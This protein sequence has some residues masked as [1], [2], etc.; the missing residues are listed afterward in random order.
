MKP[1]TLKVAFDSMALTAIIVLAN[2]WSPV[3]ATEPNKGENTALYGTL[4]VVVNAL[5]NTP[6]A[7][8]T[9]VID[10]DTTKTATLLQ[11]YLRDSATLNSLA[12]A[13]DQAE[14][15]KNP[16]GKLEELC[17]KNKATKCADAA[18]YLKSRGTTLGGHLI[19]NTETPSTVLP[20]INRTL[21]LLTNAIDQY[22]KPAHNSAGKSSK[23]LLKTAV[24]GK[25]A[26]D[27][28][29]RLTGATTDRETTCGKVEQAG[30]ASGRSIAE[31]LICIC[32]STSS[33]NN[34]GC[35]ASG[36]PTV[37]FN[38]GNNN[39]AAAWKKLK[40]GCGHFNLANSKIS[41]NDIRQTIR[42]VAQLI[43]APHGTNQKIGYLGQTHDSNTAGACDGNNDSGGKGACVNYGKSATAAN[44]PDW[45]D[46]LQQAAVALDSEAGAAQHKASLMETISSLNKTLTNLLHLHNTQVELSKEIKQSRGTETVKSTKTLEE[47]NKECEAI[48]KAGECREKEPA[49]EWKRENDDDGP[50]SKLNTRAAEKIA[51]QA[52]AGAGTMT[53]GC[54][55][56]GTDKEKCE[57]HTNGK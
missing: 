32:G 20:E 33:T 30:T 1:Q 18:K 49:C 29:V 54:A 48:T 34:K 24:L 27:D 14:E 41:V 16:K 3:A 55:R 19:R 36:A 13:T 35:L 40:E 44:K 8:S 7:T 38:A 52:G 22:N 17:G 56:H 21:G 26:A 50:H 5:E 42:Q 31:D 4:C 39:H 2:L 43:N 6:Q 53:T 10:E 57:G 9:G 25:A 15:L 37:T 51:T 46:T 23:E 12:A 28:A 45:L 47:K 11:L